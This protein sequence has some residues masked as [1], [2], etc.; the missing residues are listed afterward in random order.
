MFWQLTSHNCYVCKNNNSNYN[1]VHIWQDK[2]FWKQFQRD[3]LFEDLTYPWDNTEFIFNTFTKTLHSSLIFL[4]NCFN[5]ENKQFKDKHLILRMN[6]QEDL[7]YDI[8]ILVHSMPCSWINHILEWLVI[9]LLWFSYVKPTNY[10]GRFSSF[11]IS[12]NLMKLNRS[13]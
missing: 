6:Q 4:I 5:Q 2:M 11:T 8:N 10:K 12:I 7:N 1:K 9:V 13:L 3:Y